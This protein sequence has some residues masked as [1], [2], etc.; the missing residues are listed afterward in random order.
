MKVYMENRQ[1]IARHNQRA[2]NGLH[3][4][5]LAMN[6]FGDMLHH[7]FVALMNG[8]K[9]TWRT[10]SVNGSTYLSPHNV[11]IPDSVDWRKEGY[12]TPVKDQGQC[13]S[14]WAFST[15]SLK[16]RHYQIPANLASKLPCI[17][18]ALSKANIS[19]SLASL[20]L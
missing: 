1:K 18:L 20:F 4:Y 11:K 16:F 10:V 9:K 8:F 6:K 2:A 7:E 14:C 5:E 15:V 17:R 12:V 13:G 19:A 3:S